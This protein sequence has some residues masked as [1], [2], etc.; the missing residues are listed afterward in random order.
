[1]RVIKPID[2]ELVSSNVAADSAA[3]YAEDTTYTAGQRVLV[4]YESD[5]ETART[6]EVYTSL[7]SNNLSNY[8][9]DN[10]EEADDVYKITATSE[11]SVAGFEV[12]EVVSSAVASGTVAV[13]SGTTGGYLI[14]KDVSG[15]FDAAD[16]VTGTDS[17]A[18]VTLTSAASSTLSAWWESSGASNKWKM[19]DSYVNTQTENA[20]EIDVTIGVDRCDTLVILDIDAVSVDIETTNDSTGEVTFSASYDLRLDSSS[21]WSD[22]FFGPFLWKS[23]L[24]ISIPLYYKASA[25]IIIRHNPGEDAKCGQVVVGRAQYLGASQWSPSAGITDYSQKSTDDDGVTTLTP[26]GWAK[27]LSVD[28]QVNTSAASALQR[29]LAGYRATPCIWD[30]NNDST[31]H[32]SLV[33]YGYFSDFSIVIPGP[34]VSSCS[35]TVQGLI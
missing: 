29:N 14:I 34:T 15:E 20:D 19:F 5:G 1:M 21:S 25:R 23:M 12:G 3:A 31:D 35:L 2:I 27:E 33:V 16:I 32:E 28:M 26:G 6:E 13:I 4:A 17:S 30:G 8:P 22:Y 11:T 10:L 18:T 24:M 7:R 9:P